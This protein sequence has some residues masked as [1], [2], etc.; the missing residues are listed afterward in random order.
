VIGQILTGTNPAGDARLLADIYG[1]DMNV[2]YPNN[3]A[4]EILKIA[5]RRLRSTLDGLINGLTYPSVVELLKSRGCDRILPSAEARST[6]ALL[7]REA[8]R[9]DL[10]AERAEHDNDPDDHYRDFARSL[11]Q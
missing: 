1:D 7:V 8:V 6:L 11:T 4:F 9:R 10:E 5:H 2:H 3:I